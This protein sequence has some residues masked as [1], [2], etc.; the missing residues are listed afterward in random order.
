MN[1]SKVNKAITWSML[2]EIVAKIVVP[3]SNIILARLLAPEVFGIVASI[4][5]IVSFSEMFTSGGVA[6]YIINHEMNKQELSEVSNCSFAFNLGT[7]IGIWILVFVFRYPISSFIGCKGYA[8]ELIVAALLVPL[9]S[10]STIHEALYQRNLEYKVLFYNRLITSFIP[11]IITIPLAYLGYGCWSIICCNIVSQIAKIIFFLT[12]SS[13][14]IKPLLNMSVAKNMLSYSTWNYLDAL[15]L[16]A[17]D[18]IDILII[19]NFLGSYYTGLYKNGQS[20]VTSLFS[21]ITASMRSV[22]FSTLSKYQKDSDKFFSQYLSFQ[23]G[24]AFLVLPLGFG[25][26]CYR[27]FLVNLFLGSQWIDVTFFVGIWAISIGLVSVY[28]T[29][30]REALRAYGLPKYAF[31]SQIILMVF[32]VLGTLIT[33]RIGFDALCITRSIVALIIIAIHLVVLKIKIGFKIGRIIGATCPIYVGIAGMILLSHFIYNPEYGFFQSMICIFAC[34]IFY[35]AIMIIFP[36]YRSLVIGFINKILS[37]TK[38]VV[39]R[40]RGRKQI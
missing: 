26:F 18:W 28:S 12:R 9:S 36:S 30:S 25:I 27:R 40:N 16:W 33:S 15:S 39:L 7:G 2:A 17:T 13:Y 34:T 19:G 10:F 1:S 35:F 8:T 32:V 14:K 37:V 29:P 21:I 5:I 11:F 23:K 6:K 24:L 22:I 20:L 38:S 3:I 4:N 31:L